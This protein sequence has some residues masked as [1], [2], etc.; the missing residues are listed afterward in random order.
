MV[1]SQS[2]ACDSSICSRAETTASSIASRIVPLNSLAS[3]R[4]DG[5]IPSMLKRSKSCSSDECGLVCPSMKLR[6]E[7]KWA[8]SAAILMYRGKGSRDGAFGAGVP[9]H[10]LRGF[11]TYR[12]CS[13]R[14]L[15]MSSGPSTAV[16]PMHRTK[17]PSDLR[18]ASTP[19]G[20]LPF[21]SGPAMT[22]TPP[23]PPNVRGLM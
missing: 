20:F 12:S 9:S 4:Y 18:T 15:P 8:E 11:S 23:D 22:K 21:Q 3:K 2:T 10:E 16:R 19:C 13:A 17:F 5:P 7:M 1:S 6:Y 14:T